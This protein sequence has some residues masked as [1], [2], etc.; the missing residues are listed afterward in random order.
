[1]DV[2]S[3]DSCFCLVSYLSLGV[4]VIS[5]AV[6]V[7]VFAEDWAIFYRGAD[8]SVG[9]PG[10]THLVFVFGSGDADLFGVALS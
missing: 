7:D 3:E 5:L 8:V 9:D 4:F 1:M 10:Y 2:L 6:C